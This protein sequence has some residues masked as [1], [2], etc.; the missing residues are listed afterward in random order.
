[1]FKT[2]LAAFALCGPMVAQAATVAPLSYTYVVAPNGG[3]AYKDDTYNGVL[4]ELADGVSA[5]QDW[6]PT[7]GFNRT[8]PNVGWQNVTPT[9]RFNFDQAYDFAGLV[10]NFQDGQGTFGV[11]IPVSIT[12]NG[13]TSPM[14]TG[15][16]TA[17]ALDAP[18]DLSSLAP[19]DE[20]L[21]TVNRGPSAWIM[22]SEF[23]FEGTPASA[24]PLP[25]G[26]PMLLGALGLF[27]ALRKRRN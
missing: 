18:M 4:G 3:A 13:V 11:A 25:G 16:S 24:I 9:I 8:G 7:D 14:L 15:G 19:T 12:V 6:Q 10:M 23:T 26:L 2:L 1:M 21:V 17:G 27:A 22:L 20:L 5:T